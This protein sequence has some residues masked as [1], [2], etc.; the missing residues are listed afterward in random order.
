MFQGTI[1]SSNLDSDAFYGLG[2]LREKYLAGGR[3]RYTTT[4][5]VNDDSVWT[6]Q[7]H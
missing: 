6:K 3:G 7:Q 4:V 5:P 2:N 1:A